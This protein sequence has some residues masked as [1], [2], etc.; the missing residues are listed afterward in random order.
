ME[1]SK[2]VVIL[3]MEFHLTF[4]LSVEGGAFLSHYVMVI[5]T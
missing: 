5:L 1:I 3:G 4:N 2:E